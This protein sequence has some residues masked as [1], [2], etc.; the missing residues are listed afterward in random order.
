ML[1]VNN[2]FVPFIGCLC[3]DT[4]GREQKLLVDNK[5]FIC[6]GLPTFNSSLE[7]LHR[8]HLK[9]QQIRQGKSE[10]GV[11]TYMGPGGV[12]GDGGGDVCNFSG[13]ILDARV[14]GGRGG[15][16]PP[17]RL[18]VLQQPG[19]HRPLQLQPD[20][21]WLVSEPEGHGG[22]A[23]TAAAAAAA[24]ATAATATTARVP[25][26]Q[27]VSRLRGLRWGSGTDARLNTV[28]KDVHFSSPTFHFE[29]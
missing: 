21:W 2:C 5:L 1:Y 25:R 28:R 20:Q 24:T 22:A 9:C 10:R 14:S 7:A 4:S 23:A 26:L 12:L 19:I 15:R 3:M 11:C 29:H 13:Y 27:L 8:A 16:P 17:E 18:N 6:R